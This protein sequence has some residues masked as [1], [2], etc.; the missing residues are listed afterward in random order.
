[1]K[2]GT[3]YFR[4]TEK[5]LPSDANNW[6]EMSTQTNKNKIFQLSLYSIEMHGSLKSLFLKKRTSKGILSDRLSWDQLL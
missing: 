4:F 2:V 1:M 6:N 3:F 5:M